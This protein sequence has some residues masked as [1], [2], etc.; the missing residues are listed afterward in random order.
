MVPHSRAPKPCWAKNG[1]ASAFLSRPAASPIGEFQREDPT[2]MLRRSEGVDPES[3]P[4]VGL[5]RASESVNSCAVSG[6]S[7]KSRGRMIE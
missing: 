5:K 3:L 4:N 2:W 7:E 6:G 1:N